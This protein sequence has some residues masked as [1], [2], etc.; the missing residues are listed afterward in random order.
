MN[1]QFFNSAAVRIHPK[2][3]EIRQAAWARQ[4][5]ANLFLGIFLAEV[6]AVLIFVANARHSAPQSIWHVLAAAS[7][8]LLGITV[9][10]LPTGRADGWI[11][12]KPSDFL[13]WR[14]P[15]MDFTPVVEELKK[16]ADDTL[17]M[18]AEHFFSMELDKLEAHAESML[19]SGASMHLQLEERLNSE[20]LKTGEM[21]LARRNLLAD[22][23]NEIAMK[24]LQLAKARIIIMRDGGIVH[25]IERAKLRNKQSA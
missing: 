6:L 2:S 3:E 23:R 12:F 7:V 20:N 4:S 18:T 16:L 13:L 21:K 19:V 10:S 15:Q 11:K 17:Q 8:F 25:F 9:L 14:T 22:S 1:P 24:Y 5:Q